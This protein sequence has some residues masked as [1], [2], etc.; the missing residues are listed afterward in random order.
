VLPAVGS[1]NVV[2]GVNIREGDWR[3]LDGVEEGSGR[4]WMVRL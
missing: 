2:D 3:G 1:E 4:W